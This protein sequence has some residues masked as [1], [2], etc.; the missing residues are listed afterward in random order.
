MPL[1]HCHHLNPC[2]P[3]RVV[4]Q[5]SHRDRRLY[6]FF[7]VCLWTGVLSFAI[8]TALYVAMR[9]YV[10]FIMAL[11]CVCVILVGQFGFRWLALKNDDK[12]DVYYPND[13]SLQVGGD[14][15][16]LQQLNQGLAPAAPPPP[17][18][19]ETYDGPIFTIDGSLAPPPSYEE[20]RATADV[21][22]A[23]GG[24]STN[25]QQVN[26][27]AIELQSRDTSAAHVSGSATTSGAG[28]Q[29]Q[30]LRIGVK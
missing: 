7:H 29:Q 21:P 19:T 28:E 15:N 13:A 30:Q 10:F 25:A 3:H 4:R 26:T 27:E 2:F 22:T 14:F 24:Q 23:A 11:P 17:A 16:R 1:V 9:T 8:G 20:L 5:M 12:F 6:V 18:Y